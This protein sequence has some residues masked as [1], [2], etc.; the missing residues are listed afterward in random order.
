MAKIEKK[1]KRIQSKFS[2]KHPEN[3]TPFLEVASVASAAPI[4]RF[5]AR[6]VRAEILSRDPLIIAASRAKKG[7]ADVPEVAE[8]LTLTSEV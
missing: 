1:P 3:A 8:E 4:I 2:T 6:C 5:R 7:K